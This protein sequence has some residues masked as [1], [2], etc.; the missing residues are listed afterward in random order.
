M[1]NR[2]WVG[3]CASAKAAPPTN[4]LHL[5]LKIQRIQDLDRLAISVTN[6]VTG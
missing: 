5:K 1:A 2:E 6:A 4:A 3:P